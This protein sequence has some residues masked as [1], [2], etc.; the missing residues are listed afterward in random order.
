MSRPDPYAWTLHFEATIPIIG[1]VLAYA[2]AARRRPPERWR[3][4]AFAA[5]CLLLLATAVTPLDALTYHLLSAHLLQNVVLAEWAPA[6]LVLGLPPAFAA[7]IG[8]IRPLRVL[9]RAPLALGLWLVTYYVWHLPPLYDSALEHPALL[10]LEHAC[11]LAAGVLLW[12]PVLQDAPHR[13]SNAARALYLFLA[14]VLASPIG[15]L[16][17]LL[18]E[19]AYDWYVEGGGLWG[20]SP[21]TDQQIA[22]VTM[23]VEQA[24]VFFAVFAIFFF[25]FLAEED[26]DDHAARYAQPSDGV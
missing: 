25:R 7:R 15:L 14:F 18:P 13:L 11:Y 17:A 3:S 26:A 9:T 21:H 10:H 2:A 6:L 23:S 1:L 12:W 19:P 16:L 24:I 22:G 4:A 5:G 8:G 20:L